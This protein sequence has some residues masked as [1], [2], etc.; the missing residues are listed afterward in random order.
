LGN[1]N[2]KPLYDSSLNEKRLIWL[3]NNRL[4]DENE[5]QQDLADDDVEYPQ[6]QQDQ[7]QGFGFQSQ[8][9]QFQGFG[10]Q[11]Q[12]KQFQGFGL[13]AYNDQVDT[14]QQ[15]GIEFP[16]ND[17]MR[18]SVSAEQRQSFTEEIPPKGFS[19]RR[20]GFD[21]SLLFDEELENESDNF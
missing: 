20:D 13:K 14:Q 18:R 15:R 12:S 5:E 17:Q 21:E 3:F 19:Q 2:Q 1:S 6:Y 16:D 10:H 11:A 7:L 9:N 4:Y 8:N